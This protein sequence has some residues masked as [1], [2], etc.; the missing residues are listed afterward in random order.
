MD[1][2]LHVAV[3]G[4][5]HGHFTLAYRVLKR[6]EAETGASLGLILQVGDLGAFPP[7][8]R[9]DKATKRFAERDP[10]ELGFSDYYEPS[11]EAEQFFGDDADAAVRVAT[12]MV[13]IKGNHEDFEFLEEQGAGTDAPVPVDHYGRVH[14]LKNGARY[15]FA[16][17]PHALTIAAL[18]GIADDGVP[19]A[20]SASPFYTGSEVRR[21]RARGSGL[22]VFLSHE[23]PYGAAAVVHPKYEDAGSREVLAFIADFAPRFHFCGHYHEPGQALRVPGATQSYILN[24]VNFLR[25]SRLNPGCI[26]VLTWSGREPVDFQVL[27]APWLKQF[28]K[29][30]YRYL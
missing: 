21:L 24:A 10:D 17:G 30:N 6:W 23:P 15:T 8:F 4:D 7:P 20:E 18:G 19:G 22:D 11:A 2:R 13:F 29:A 25:P 1:D 5:L 16:R 12:D 3:L 9:L 28:T 14:Y 27:D 26:G